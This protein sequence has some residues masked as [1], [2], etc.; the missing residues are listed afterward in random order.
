MDEIHE[1]SI[2]NCQ[3]SRR[4]ADGDFLRV[5]ADGDDDLGE[6]VRHTGAFRHEIATHGGVELLTVQRA[7]ELLEEVVILRSGIVGADAAVEGVHALHMG[8]KAVLNGNL[9]GALLLV[10]AWIAQRHSVGFA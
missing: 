10:G 3:L 9:T 7:G 2:I 4:E 5:V 6:V 8:M 1:L